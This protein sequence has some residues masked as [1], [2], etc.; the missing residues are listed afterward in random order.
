MQTHEKYPEDIISSTSVLV[1]EDYHTAPSKWHS[2]DM[3][4]Q[5]I[6]SYHAQPFTGCGTLFPSGAFCKEV[7]NKEVFTKICPFADDLWL[8]FMALKAHTPVTAVY[9]YRDI[10]MM[11]YGTAKNGLWQINGQEN[12]N[13]EQW[14]ALLKWYGDKDLPGDRI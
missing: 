2:P 1:P 4:Q 10:P 12:K 14:E 5:L 8:Y 13:D 3:E 6:H 7:F 11:I 9:P